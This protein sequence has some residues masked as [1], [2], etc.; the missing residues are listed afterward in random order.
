MLN[1]ILQTLVLCVVVLLLTTGVAWSRPLSSPMLLAEHTP[2]HNATPPIETTQPSNQTTP[3]SSPTNP[4]PV[5][6]P[7]ATAVDREDEAATN[8]AIQANPSVPYDPYDI[9]AMRE[10]NREIYGEKPGKS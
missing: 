6:T 2:D 4:P 8:Q 7:D 10:M 9:N 1:R 3:S 5:N